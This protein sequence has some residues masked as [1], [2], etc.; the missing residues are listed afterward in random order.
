MTRIGG[1]R[2]LRL[3][4]PDNTLEGLLA[5][6]ALCDFAEIDVRA[7]ADGVL[8]LSHDASVAGRVISEETWTDLAELDLG[9]GYPPVR[10]RD[11]LETLPDFPLDI[12]IK[13][14][15]ADPDFDP[16]HERGIRTARRARPHDVI[17]SF[18]WP[19]MNAVKQ[20]LPHVNTG[21]LVGTGWSVEDALEAASAAGHGAVA[22]HDSLLGADPAG[23]VEAAHR[24]GVEVLVWTV[25]DPVRATVLASAGIDAIISDDPRTIRSVIEENQ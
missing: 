16:T 8:M 12:E 25:D 10:L 15:P 24:R 18:N 19:T 9:G 20:A 4:Y 14:S 22:L 1:H 23:I 21:L 2:G 6:A 7:T 3:E 5:A 13:N 11:V 17:T